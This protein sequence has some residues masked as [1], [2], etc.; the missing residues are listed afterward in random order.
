MASAFQQQVKG[1]L[2]Q[3]SLTKTHAAISKSFRD[4]RP[5]NRAGSGKI[6]KFDPTAFPNYCSFRFLSRLNI[7]FPESKIIRINEGL[8]KDAAALLY[9]TI[10]MVQAMGL[11][12]LSFRKTTAS[13]NYYLVY[14]GKSAICL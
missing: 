9:A 14:R 13:L 11:D 2:R 6:L 3:L 1:G 12:L 8:S 10:S 5:G 7:D 4:F